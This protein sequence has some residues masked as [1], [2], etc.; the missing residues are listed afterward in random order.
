MRLKPLAF[1]VVLLSLV[2]VVSASGEITK[3]QMEAQISF[4]NDALTEFGAS[5]PEQAVQLWVKGDQARNG[6]F[7]YS[8]SCDKLKEWL[9]NRW[10]DPEKSF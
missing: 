1:T 7:K 9:I 4:F 2:F 8:V 3:Q 6:V 5:T 10:G